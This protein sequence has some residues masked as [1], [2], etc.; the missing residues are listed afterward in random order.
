MSRAGP[1]RILTVPPPAAPAAP[2]EG[3]GVAPDVASYSFTDRGPWVVE[4]S[5]LAWYRHVLATR[6]RVHREVP[7]LVRRRR[8]PPSRRIARVAAELGGALAG[9]YVVDRRKGRQASRLGL[10]RRLRVGFGHLGPTY[11]KLGQIL[12]SGEGI[13]PEEVVSQFKLLRDRVP[14]EPFEVVRATL[15]AELA[16]RLSATFREFDRDPIAAASIAQVHRAVLHDGKEVVVKVQRKQ[17]AELVRRD[18]AVMSFIAPLLVGRIPVAALANPPALIELFAETIAEEL[19][20]RLEAANMLDIGRVLAMTNQRSIVVPRPHPTLVTRR[21]LV[22]ERLSGFAWDDV[23]GM[24]TAGIDT[25]TVLRGETIAFLEGA[26]L[27]G[28]F[29]GDL[30]GGNL[31]VQPGGRVALLDHG[32]TGRLDEPQRQAFLRLLVGGTTN[33]VALQIDALRTLGAIPEHAST[34]EVI[35]DLGLDKPAQDILLLSTEEL[36]AQMRDL[37]RQLLSYGVRMPKELML[38]VKDLLF[39]D[40][41]VA[42]MAPE[43]DLLGEVAL[44]AAYFAQHH[45]QQIAAEVGVD[46]RSTPVDLD[47]LRASMG[48]STDT[49]E[50]T[51]RELQQRRQSLRQR[52]EHPRPDEE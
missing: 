19:D 46:V 5:E 1:V 50:I 4:A 12:S 37:T 16:G 49:R 11:I 45:G 30:H 8:L 29:H 40:S 18:L 9:W 2:G 6:D 26:L 21:M 22:M 28:V 52:F 25:P 13:F 20:F 23:S 43:I 36:T 32:I 31:F 33:D 41:A 24:R 44:I 10:S 17:V 38:F 47:G 48:L 3:G 27:Y 7:R 39:L 42:T 35:R 51:H 14:A 15:E 34:A